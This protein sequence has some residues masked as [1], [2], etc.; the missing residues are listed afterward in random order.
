MA[1]EAAAS[2]NDPWALLRSILVDADGPDA[3]IESGFAAGSHA[4]LNAIGDGDRR[5]LNGVWRKL[6]RLYE[7]LAAQADDDYD[8]HPMFLLGRVVSLVEIA[9][10]AGHRAE[11]P[12][13]VAA[14]ADDHSTAL[15]R[16][17]LRLE[18]AS[19]TELVTALR[20]DRS[21][22]SRRLSRLQSSGLV[23]S[24]KDGRKLYSRLPFRVRQVLATRWPE[25]VQTHEDSPDSRV[26]LA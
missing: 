9:N 2:P 4:L 10:A 15:L 6:R 25:L 22:L 5:E 23:I 20:W 13:L 16:T 24:R 1:T 7:V 17:L 11:P 18:H 8:T 26:T 21:T 14:L 19:S 3:D 12:E